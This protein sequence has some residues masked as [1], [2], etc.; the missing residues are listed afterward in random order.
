MP[1]RCDEGASV[2]PS[3]RKITL[4]INEKYCKRC[5]ICIEFCPEHVFED[6]DGLPVIADIARCTGCL[7]CELLCP[8]F[9]IEV[10]IEREK[11]RAAEAEG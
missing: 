8:D 3:K 5:R 11:R 4:D 1:R 6:R 2:A 9:A 7:Q 10:H